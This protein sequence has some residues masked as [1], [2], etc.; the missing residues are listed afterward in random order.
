[1][2][3]K[4]ERGIELKNRTD[5]AHYNCCQAVACVFSS[6]AGVYEDVLKRIGAGF[7]LGMGGRGD[8]QGTLRS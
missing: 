3:A 1:M 5:D 4:Q 2:T 8:M 7:G 6:E